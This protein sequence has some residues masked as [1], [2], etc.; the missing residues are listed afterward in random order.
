MHLGLHWRV[1][2]HSY[3]WF[4]IITNV[5]MATMQETAVGEHYLHLQYNYEVW[6]GGRSSKIIQRLW[7]IEFMT[8]SFYVMEVFLMEILHK[9]W[10]LI[11]KIFNLKYLS[12]IC[13]MVFLLQLLQFRPSGLFQ[14]RMNFW[15]YKPFQT[16]GRTPWAGDWP[17]TRPLLTQDSTTQKHTTIHASSGIWVSD[18][19]VHVCPRPNDH[20]HQHI[21]ISFYKMHRVGI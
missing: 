9:D 8:N 13:N 15:N 4:H 11:Y 19:I 17:I 1:S 20:F 2:A 21:K 5:N 7:N 6:C 12:K 16:F 14:F 3:F 10:S 18:H